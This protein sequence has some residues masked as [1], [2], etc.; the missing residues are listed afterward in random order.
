[1]MDK[2]PRGG[3][4]PRVVGTLGDV[5]GPE[6][7]QEGTYQ[8]PAAPTGTT[9]NADYTFGKG[10]PMFQAAAKEYEAKTGKPMD[11]KTTQSPE[12]KA[13]FI[14]RQNDHWRRG[15]E[16]LHP[17]ATPSEELVQRNNDIVIR[18]VTSAISDASLKD[19]NLTLVGPSVPAAPSQPTAPTAELDMQNN[20]DTVPESQVLSANVSRLPDWLGTAPEQVQNWFI[21]SVTVHNT[22]QVPDAGNRGG[23]YVVKD[24]ALATSDQHAEITDGRPPQVD[25]LA[26]MRTLKYAGSL[27]SVEEFDAHIDLEK[28]LTE[29]YNKSL[30]RGT[31]EA[32]DELSRRSEEPNS[33]R[34][35]DASAKSVQV[36]VKGNRT[37][38]TN[39]DY[40]EKHNIPEPKWWPAAK[41]RA[42]HWERRVDEWE[43][44]KKRKVSL[45]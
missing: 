8:P 23:N 17:G 26:P 28:K 43:K 33:R 1:M 15:F 14:Q 24:N 19:N 20:T 4:V 42:E 38:K 10:G 21:S 9:L 13:F 22:P 12:F 41:P 16:K 7:F 37:I 27:E 44:P 5:Q 3:N 30:I 31:Q 35:S 39:K 45:F 36:G 34:S 29:A 6:F 40:V 25:Q 11:Y 18:H 32:M 2:I